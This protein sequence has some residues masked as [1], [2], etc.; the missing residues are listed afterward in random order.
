MNI[1]RTVILPDLHYPYTDMPALHAALHFI[2]K[3]RPQRIVLLGDNL[4]CEPVSRHSKGKPGL[5]EKGGLRRDIDGF[6]RNILSPI[7]NLAP[8]AEKWFFE[9]NHEAWVQQT[10]DEQPELQGCID[11]P[12]LL[13]LKQRGWEWVQQGETRY[14]SRA[15]LLHGDSVGAGMHVSKKLVDA[16]CTTA[17]MGHVHTLGMHTKTS[18]ARKTDKWLG[19]TLPCLSSL[20]PRYAKNQPNSWLHG[21]GIIEEWGR[22]FNLYVPIITEGKFVYGGRQ[23]GK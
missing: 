3:N 12:T 11:L 10:I 14:V 7:E 6:V 19:V 23:Y 22:F 18:L 9:G 21:F 8:S 5:R 1:S 16:Y 13:N 2:R 15:V 4:D 20:A 17:I